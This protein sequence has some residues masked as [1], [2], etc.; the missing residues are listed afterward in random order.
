MATL[1]PVDCRTNTR[2]FRCCEVEH[3]D[4][5]RH[6]CQ[7]PESFGSAEITGQDIE[8]A[9]NWLTAFAGATSSATLPCK[10]KKP[11]R[12]AVI[13]DQSSLC[14]NEMTIAVQLSL[15]RLALL[16]AQCATKSRKCREL[17]E[18]R[19]KIFNSKQ[20]S[21]ASQTPPPTPLSQRTRLDQ[22]CSPKKKW[23]RLKQDL[24]KDF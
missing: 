21:S 3:T 18:E 13:V 8:G 11:L 24:D 16:I 7:R 1:V 22:G 23:G 6:C 12:S 14:D 17:R 10:Q 9:E 20:G 15:Y 2:F 19:L 5:S 4:E